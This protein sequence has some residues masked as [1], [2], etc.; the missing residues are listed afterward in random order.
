MLPVGLDA[1]IQGTQSSTNMCARVYTSTISAPLSISSMAQNYEVSIKDTLDDWR[2]G[3]IL[4]VPRPANWLF[5]FT[6]VGC[7]SMDRA[8]WDGIT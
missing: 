2:S 1:N 6:L 5:H 8:P 7:V 3:N 4:L